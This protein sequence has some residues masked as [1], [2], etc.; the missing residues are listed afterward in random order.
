VAAMRTREH[1]PDLT[2]APAQSCGPSEAPERAG[3]LDKSARATAIARLPP[4]R[5]RRAAEV[6]PDG[7]HGTA[8]RCARGELR[9]T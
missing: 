7:G 3:Y 5:F 6:P 9:R 2:F 4:D 1:H 8:L